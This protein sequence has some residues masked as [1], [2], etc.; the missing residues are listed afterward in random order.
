M[1]WITP[2]GVDSF[3]KAS[4]IISQNIQDMILSTR[5]LATKAEDTETGGE[6]ST[7]PRLYG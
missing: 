6:S 1:E 4:V 7:L 2:L 3:S 5:A